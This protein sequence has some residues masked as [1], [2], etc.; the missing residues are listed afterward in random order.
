M[1]F[2]K[3]MTA[4]YQAFIDNDFALF[5]INPLSVRE[6]GDIL[7]VDAKVGID[8]NALYRLPEVAW[9]CAIKHKKMNV[10]CKHQNLT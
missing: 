8:S 7:C 3:I 5:E 10:N 6:N 4:A 2:V 1:Q 9:H